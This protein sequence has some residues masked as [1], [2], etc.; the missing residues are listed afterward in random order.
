MLL[1]LLI[2]PHNAEI[3]L[4]SVS[5]I[6]SFSQKQNQR[7]KREAKHQKWPN[8]KISRGAFNTRVQQIQKLQSMQHSLTLF[9]PARSPRTGPAQPWLSRRCVY[10]RSPRSRARCDPEPLTRGRV[11]THH[12]RQCGCGAAHGAGRAERT[13]DTPSSRRRGRP[14]TEYLSGPTAKPGRYNLRVMAW[15]LSPLLHNSQRV[16][17]VP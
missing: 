6:C 3:P 12:G 17:N 14:A 9:I 13:H 2:T 4:I 11:W 5:I 16:F 1:R 10:G 7:D 15:S 8:R